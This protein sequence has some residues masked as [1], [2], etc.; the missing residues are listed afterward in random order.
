[1]VP[2]DVLRS[3]HNVAPVTDGGGDEMELAQSIKQVARTVRK[4]ALLWRSMVLSSMGKTLFPYCR[5]IRALDLRD[6]N[7][8]LDDDKFKGAIERSATQ[9]ISWPLLFS[10][11]TMTET[12][13]RGP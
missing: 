10:Q 3:M 13:F 6:L 4:W 5:Y 2:S 7:H 12:S 9:A 11:L 1:M 8:L